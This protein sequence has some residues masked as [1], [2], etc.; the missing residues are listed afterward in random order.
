MRQDVVDEFRR[1]RGHAPAPATRTKP[2]PFTRKRDERFGVTAVGLKTRK[3]AGPNATV[4]EAAELLLEKRGEA[5]G[6]GTGGSREEG[7]QVLAH[8][9]VE[10]G[11]FGLAGRVPQGRDGRSAFVAGS[12]LA[13][14]GHEPRS[15]QSHTLA[16]S[17]RVGSRRC[18]AGASANGHDGVRI[19]GDHLR[20]A[21]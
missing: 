11:A 21:G 3:I 7:F 19:E 1:P 14:C 9:L 5:G 8:H 13:H 17:L 2:A 20:H 18:G 4:Q 6:I 12:G 10:H 16:A 15:W